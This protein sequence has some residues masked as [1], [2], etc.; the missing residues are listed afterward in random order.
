MC[1]CL[2]HAKKVDLLF[3]NFQSDRCHSDCLN[4]SISLQRCFHSSNRV[5]CGPH[6]PMREGLNFEAAQGTPHN[7][8]SKPS[9]FVRS[10]FEWRV[11]D[12][13]E[14]AMIYSRCT[15]GPAVSKMAIW[16]LPLHWLDSWKWHLKREWS[17]M[18]PS[19][20]H[21]FGRNIRH[22][23]IIYWLICIPATLQ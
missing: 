7:S 1:T 11:E 4:E 2:I 23:K 5:A 9:N 18:L 13:E 3:R 22:A 12:M 19:W 14:H 15:C 10:S 8:Y 16:P 21:S 17:Q 6:V 20:V